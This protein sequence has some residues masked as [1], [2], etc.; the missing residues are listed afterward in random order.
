MK[1]HHGEGIIGKLKAYPSLSAV[2]IGIFAALLVLTLIEIGC[3]IYEQCVVS[4]EAAEEHSP[5]GFIQKDD[6]LGCVMR[7]SSRVEAVKKAADGRKIYE[8]HYA[9]DQWGRR[10][11]PLCSP[12]QKPF[13]ILFLGCSFTF[14]EGLDQ[15][16]TLPYFVGKLSPCY[17]PY[18]YACIG[19]GPGQM[20][21]KLQSGSLSKEISQKKGLL[22]YGYMGEQSVGHIDRAVGTL[23]TFGWTRYFPFYFLDRDGKLARNGDFDTGRPIRSLVYRM[24]R[25][26]AIVRVFGINYPL[27][28]ADKDVDLTARI[29][30]ES[31]RVYRK[32]FL[33]QPFYVLIFPGAVESTTRKLVSKLQ[34]AGIHCLD[35]TALS[36]FAD[37]EYRIAG[38]EHPSVQWNKELAGLIVRDLRLG[39]DDCGEPPRP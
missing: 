28:V 14:G 6:L 1:S 30:E 17:Q 12:E 19:Y 22:I 4:R 8:V 36:Q 39:D 29:I 21:A 2:F 3:R 34:K 10:I 15:D 23:Y 27:G 24:L 38:D 25:K 32:D 20:L 5:P 11:T 13:Y 16:E 26:S 33:D 31:C 37:P 7:P 35:Y 9:T 18:N